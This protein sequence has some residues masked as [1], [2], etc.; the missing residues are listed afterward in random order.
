M[1][2]KAWFATVVVGLLT[3]AGAGCAEEAPPP[4]MPAKVYV[5]WLIPKKKP[6]PEPPPAAASSE[7][8][9]QGTTVGDA[10]GD[11]E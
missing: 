7:P 5:P 3:L 1:W 4:K 11:G 10:E 6:Q 9:P 2:A 8:A